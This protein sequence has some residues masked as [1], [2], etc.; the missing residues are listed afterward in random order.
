MGLPPIQF[1]APTSKRGWRIAVARTEENPPPRSIHDRWK[2]ARGAL[3]AYADQ[4]A[5][6]SS[7]IASEAE[8][9]LLDEPMAA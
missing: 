5:L 9:L 2:H 6:E 8:I 4:R 3:L 1:W 7:G